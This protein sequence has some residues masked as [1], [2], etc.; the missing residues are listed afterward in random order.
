MHLLHA[1]DTKVCTEV[2]ARREAYMQTLIHIDYI[3]LFLIWK[4]PCSLLYKQL[5]YIY[6][7]VCL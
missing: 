4:V 2:K 7:V 5:T 6:A 1:E 3:I